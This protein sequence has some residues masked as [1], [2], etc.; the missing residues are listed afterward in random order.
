MMV[1]GSG[2]WWWVVVGGGLRVMVRGP[3]RQKFH[4]CEQE[5]FSEMTGMRNLTSYIVKLRLRPWDLSYRVKRPKIM[6]ISW[7][8]TAVPHDLSTS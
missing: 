4:F 3:W 6:V 8:E 2:R 5:C 7:E 1:A